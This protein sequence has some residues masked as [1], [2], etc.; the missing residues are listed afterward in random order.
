MKIA[1][2]DSFR[3]RF[4]KQYKEAQWTSGIPAEELMTRLQELYEKFETEGVPY[5]VAKAKILRFMLGQL[6]IAVNAFD[7]FAVICERNEFLTYK[8]WERNGKYAVPHLGEENRAR[9]KEAADA[10]EFSAGIDLSHTSP[11]WDAVLT[12]GAPGLLKRAEDHYAQTP[13]PFYEAVKITFTAFREFILRFS[14]DARSAGRPDLAEM[15]AFLADHAPETLQQALELGLLYR[16]MQELEGELVRSMGLFDRQYYRFYKHDLETGILTEKSAFELLTVY[17]SHCH[18]QAS[19]YANMHYCF[20]GRLPDGRDGCNELTALS[21]EAF[22]RLGAVDPKFSIRVN[23]DTPQELLNFAAETVKEGKSAIL[24]IN[25]DV[26]RKAFL[27]N[28]KAPEDLHN[29]IPIGCYEPAIMGKELCCSMTGLINMAKII[30][31]MTG[32]PAFEPHSFDE[33]TARCCRMLRDTL[34]TMMEWINTTEKY[35]SEVNP[36]TSISGTMLECMERGRDASAAGSKY[37]AS[38]IM[39]AGIG[40]V[41]DSLAAI[42]YLVFER[43]LVTFAQLREMLRNNWEGAEKMRLE[44]LHRAPKWG[45]GDERA[46]E[47]AKQVAECVAQTIETHPNGKGGHFQMGLW[48]IDY[49]LRYGKLTGATPDGRKA[50]ESISKNTGASIGCDREGI[51]GMIASAVKL[52]HTHFADGSVLDVMLVARSVAGAEGSA[53]LLN[54]FQTF[55]KQG[56][57][58]MHFNILSP[59][60]LRAA[61]KE[62]EKYQNL[63][64]RLCGWNVRFIDLQK[65]MQDCLIREAESKEA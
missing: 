46:D 63:Q 29:F 64:I 12:L 3:G 60:A 32:D 41:T 33:V 54:V 1:D 48:S 49:S 18:A 15:T 53:F 44:A 14:E 7:S 61:Q 35:W 21:F 10:G 8:S 4:E 65:E 58:F 59:G 36:T 17:F 55:R 28:G 26:V 47:L 16:E 38:G 2:F 45:N 9:R 43:K 20:G 25:E 22:R 30:E 51:A 27:R 57:A 13:T 5:A 19:C 56:G 31:K 42:R 34:N 37:T 50:G 6:R 24:F 62:P 39:C 11:D 40:T 23:D 52:D